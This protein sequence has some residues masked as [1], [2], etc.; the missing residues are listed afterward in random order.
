[1][2]IVRREEPS[3]L[4]RS[5]R[6]WD[7]FQTMRE[8]MRWDPFAEMTP[9]MWRGPDV[10]FVPAF[11]VRETKD[12]YIFKADLPGFKDHDLDINVSGNRLTISGK[13]ESEHVEDADTYYCWERSYGSFTRTFTLPEGVDADQIEADLKDGVLSLKVHKTAE[14][15][16]K[17]IQL[18]SSRNDERKPRA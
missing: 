16:P 3:A 18:R 11:D 6:E 2:A 1:M 12:G 14:A 10:A 17:K 15:Q 9:R 5:T 7:P 13:R 4:S 8:L